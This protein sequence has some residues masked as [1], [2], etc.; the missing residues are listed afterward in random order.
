MFLLSPPPLPLLYSPDVP[1]AVPHG[2]FGKPSLGEGRRIA[3]YGTD[4]LFAAGGPYAQALAHVHGGDA[5]PKTPVHLR[6]VHGTG[7][8][9]L[10]EGGALPDE[11]P[12]ADAVVTNRRDVRLIVK[13]ADCVP[14]LLYAKDGSGAGAIH[15]GWRG[16]CKGVVAEAVAALEKLTGKTAGAFKALV[17]PCIRKESYAVREDFVAEAE[18]YLGDAS[19]YLSAVPEDGYGEERVYFDLPLLV[20]DRLEQAGV[21]LIRDCGVDTRPEGSGFFS[22]RRT[23]IEKRPYKFQNYAAVWLA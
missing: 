6:Q 1:P 7:V 12:E 20:R 8:A 21:S 22:Y 9:V 14:I 10:A 4:A 5:V 11:P 23:C 19:R 15:A 17:G 18:R 16:A 3:E 13:T 2:F